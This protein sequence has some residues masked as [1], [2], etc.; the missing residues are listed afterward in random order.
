[1]TDTT[2]DRRQRW[3]A[4]S[5]RAHRDIGSLASEVLLYD[6]I[7]LPLPEDHLEHERWVRQGWDP[8]SIAL[9]RAQA[10]GLIIPAHWTAQLQAEWKPRGTDSSNW[11]TRLPTVSPERST[12][13]LPRRGKR[14]KLACSL[15][16][17]QSSNHPS[18]QDTGSA[19]RRMAP[20]VSSA[21]PKERPAALRSY[22]GA[23]HKP[24]DCDL[25]GA[26][27]GGF[28]AGNGRGPA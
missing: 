8:D 16:S 28:L 9:R 13:H 26:V 6:R 1:M 3:A 17:G 18:W 14:L 19:I 27:L 25:A 5:V 4:F 2:V 24:S 12:Q 23:A 7:A 21:R 22:R 11:G 10:A 20:V 15:M